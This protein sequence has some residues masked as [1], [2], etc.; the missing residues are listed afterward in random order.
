MAPPLRF[1]R[2]YELVITVGSTK[3]TIKP[4]MRIAF[5]C[6]KS[7]RGGLNSLNLQVSNLQESTRLKLVKD[8]E[9]RKR[10]LIELS[11]GYGDSLGLIYKGSVM[12]GLNARNGADIVTTLDCLDGGFDAQRSY[13]SRTLKSG[14]AIVDS[15]LGDMVNTEKGKVTA[16]SDLLRPKVL[17]GNSLKLLRDRL[18][19]DE[20]LFIDNEQ[21]SIIKNDEVVSRLIPI[22]NAATG[23]ISTPEREQKRV[24][25]KTQLNPAIITGGLSK[26]E[27]KTAP[28]LDGI[29]KIDTIS[30]SGDN[31]G[32]E[33]AQACT[34]ELRPNYKVL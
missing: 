17:V 33:W 16:Q 31:Y 27:A 8:T 10:I 22:V 29:Y 18:A 21:L 4:P 19:D 7:T 14:Q 11:I 1:D 25:F 15:V 2:N 24:T 6:D 28:H 13:T 20:A 34:G 32:S 3:I 5:N 30:Y 9:E 12:T 23:L 26:L